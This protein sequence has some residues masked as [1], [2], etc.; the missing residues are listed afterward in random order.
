LQRPR[1][2]PGFLEIMSFA[3]WGLLFRASQPEL[4]RL[5]RRRGARGAVAEDLAQEA[6]L[7]VLHA[8]PAGGLRDARAYLFR[9]AA[10]LA[11]DHSRHCRASPVAPVELPAEANDPCPSAE[12]VA[13][14]R[15]AL[16]RLQ[17]A[18]EALP[19][20]AREVFRLARL[21]GLSQVEIAERL[22]ISPKTV[23]SHLV[24]A[25]ARL[26]AEVDDVSGI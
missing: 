26:K 7:R 11:I 9:T 21:E 16:A 23:F 17:A 24:A 10:N 20:R 3:D 5:L 8:A 1:Q 4:L 25:L 2:K 15:Q 19:P 13:M 14:D 12:R 18:V 22:G 6:F